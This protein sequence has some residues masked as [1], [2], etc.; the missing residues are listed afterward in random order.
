[1]C[2]PPNKPHI[3]EIYSEVYHLVCWGSRLLS[4]LAPTVHERCVH[5]FQSTCNQTQKLLLF[6]LTTPVHFIAFSYLQRKERHEFYC[7]VNACLD[8][9]Y[10]FSYLL[11]KNM[12]CL[13]SKPGRVN[14]ELTMLGSHPLSS[15]FSGQSF[16]ANSIFLL[17]LLNR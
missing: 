3:T 13:E 15:P 9:P 2:N 6:L 4:A 1:M 8:V 17:M 12:I 16:C 14:G 7:D 11:C 5:L 10:L